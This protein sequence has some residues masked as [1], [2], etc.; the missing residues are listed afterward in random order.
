[1]KTW[2]PR[3]AQWAVRLDV[4]FDVPKLDFRDIKGVA[5]LTARLRL[6]IW[7]TTEK[8]LSKKDAVLTAPLALIVG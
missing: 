5:V 7:Q 6:L 1:M 8:G 4:A 2:L 3:S